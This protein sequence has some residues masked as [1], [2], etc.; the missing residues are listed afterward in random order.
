MFIVK[1]TEYNFRN[2][3]K[4]L[5]AKKNTTTYGLRS[6]KYTSAKLWNDISPDTIEETDLADFKIFLNYLT[7]DRL[8]PYF[9]YV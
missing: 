4:L 1:E 8:D 7:H 5:Q 3:K 2:S 9:N 6:I